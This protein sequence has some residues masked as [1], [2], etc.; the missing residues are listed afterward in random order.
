VRGIGAGA[1][2]GTTDAHAG[3]WELF[4]ALYRGDERLFRSQNRVSLR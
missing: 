2:Q 1:F 3:Q 4:I